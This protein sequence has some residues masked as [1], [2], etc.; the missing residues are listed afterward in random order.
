MKNLK[1]NNLFVEVNDKCFLVAVG[2]YD[3]EL[4]FKI[5]EKEVFSPSGF[6]NGKIIDLEKA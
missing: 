5:T 2:E 1:K 4:N 3:D 6:I